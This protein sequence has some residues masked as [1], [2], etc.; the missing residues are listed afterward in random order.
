LIRWFKEEDE[1]KH[2]IWTLMIMIT[3]GVIAITSGRDPNA[4]TT[5]EPHITNLLV[6]NLA[7]AEG[8]LRNVSTVEVAPGT[9]D[10][11]YFRPGSEVLYVLEGAGTVR[12][13]GTRPV[14]LKAGTVVEV[15]PR[16]SQIITNT[17]QTQT[18]KVL[19]VNVGETEQPR[20]VLTKSGTRQ[21][22]EARQQNDGCQL[23][24]DGDNHQN[25]NEQDITMKGLVF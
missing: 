6:T 25:T 18:L 16:H 5:G 24:P 21:Q 19:V 7:G 20:A 17:S 15:A 1:M 22:K 3:V 10:I 2:I 12:T 4:Q 11:R 14:A 13:G 8:K 23:I 9:V